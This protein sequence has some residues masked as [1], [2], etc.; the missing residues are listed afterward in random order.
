[1]REDVL[2]VNLVK[3]I[4]NV[5]GFDNPHAL[6]I[7]SGVTYRIVRRLYN[8]EYIKPTTPIGTLY[9]ISRSLG[10]TVDDLFR[11]EPT[12]KE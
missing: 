4:A 10:V 11:P 5:A 12:P 3:Q 7:D 8:A 9:K 6:A 1:M 2:F